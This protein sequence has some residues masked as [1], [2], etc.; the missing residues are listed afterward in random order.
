MVMKQRIIFL[1][2]VS[3]MVA[4][5][6]PAPPPTPD[7]ELVRLYCDLAL[8]SDDTGPP[9]P[10]SLRA[11]VFERYGTTLEEF[12]D[13]LRP[14]REDPRGWVLFFGAV[15]DTLEARVQGAMS[16]SRVPRVRPRAPNR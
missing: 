8:I 13:A 5:G 15:V 12:E 1:T 7:P 3:L 16:R 14:F 2:L 6:R 4:C 11:A 10:D 9:A